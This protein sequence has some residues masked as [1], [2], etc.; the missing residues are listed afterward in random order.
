MSGPSERFYFVGQ[1]LDALRGYFGSECCLEPDGATAYLSLYRLLDG[2][3]YGGLGYGPDGTRL[4]PEASWGAGR[5]GALQTATEFGVPHLA[6]GLFMAEEEPNGLA[7]I[8]AGEFDEEIRHLAEFI[9]S[10]RGKV[11]LRIGYEFDGAWNPG[12]QD[13]EK[14]IAAWRRIVDLHREVGT[15][16]AIF[17]WQA[18]ASPI[19]DRIEGRREDIRD[20]YPGDDYVDYMGI[21]WFLPPN[22]QQTVEGYTA[23]T[24]SAL[25]EELFLFARAR[26]KYV[27][28]AES[29]PQGFDINERFTANISPIWDGPSAE[30]RTPLTDNEIWEIWFAP[31]FEMI[32]ENADIVRAVAYIN[33]DWDSQP[34]WGH[35]YD[36]GFWGD[37][38]LESNALIAERFST[39][40]A[41]WRQAD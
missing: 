39:A 12:Y 8:I 18:S 41:E 30:N 9:K 11:F 15:D 21:S 27:M 4:S 38:R 31:Y 34:M 17:V 36:N 2:E 10:R 23:P 24:Q 29:A 22:E 40:M 7:R 20:W 19:D 16:N 32:N 3:D 26:G 14:F 28:I 1:D 6:I 37:T 13:T 5:V 25:A 33:V 35:P